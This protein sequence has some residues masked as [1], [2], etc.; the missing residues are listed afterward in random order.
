LGSSVV[1]TATSFVPPLVNCGLVTY[2]TIP[3]QPSYLTVDMIGLKITVLATVTD[4]VGTT[5][6][7]LRATS[8]D[9]PSMT[10]DIPFTV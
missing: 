1:S 6:Y 8:N 4:P 5:S 2:V 3:A 9:W 10:A 7:I